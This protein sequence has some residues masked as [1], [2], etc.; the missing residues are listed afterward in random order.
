MA[1]E[2]TLD[3]FQL[4]EILQVVAQQR[5]TGILTIQGTDDIVAVS[6]LEGKIVA[7][8]S[9]TETT[10][11]GVGEVLV[12]DGILEPETLRR[13]SGQS[14]QGGPR[15]GD[16]LVSEDYVSRERYLDALRD[17]TLNLLI[18]L[19][20]WRSGEFKFYG[21]DEVSYEEGFRPI[22]VDELL[23]RSLEEGAETERE[24]LPEESSRLRP[25]ET[26]RSLRVLREEDLGEDPTPV[27]DGDALWLSPEEDRV[28][29]ALRPEHTVGEV[30]E[31]AGVPLDRARYVL[32][33]LSR[34]GLVARVEGAAAEPAPSEVPSEAPSGSG[35]E[36][37]EPATD[38]PQAGVAPSPDLGVPSIEMP[39]VAEEPATPSAR[40]ETSTA[41]P[42][43]AP[44]ERRPPA[45]APPRPSARPGTGASAIAVSI[46]G[47]L[48]LIL[49]ALVLG[50]LGLA[51]GL[52]LEPF[53]WLGAE[54]D[55]LAAMRDEA[56]Q[57][58]IDRA[59]KTYFLLQ[60]HF[61]DRLEDLVEI[62]LLQPDDLFD[63]RG[64]ALSYRAREASYELGVLSS[65]PEADTAVVREG[66]TG[67]FLLDPEF[68]APPEGAQ[69]AEAPLVLLD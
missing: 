60:G 46:T 64:R 61:P 28:L 66:I 41:A 34:A 65:D 31:I 53:P 51:P 69:E 9:L 14:V 59:A 20:E 62:G 32:Y 37:G 42:A 25:L 58:E 5:K 33:R 11:E 3:L 55:E 22:A 10:E 48:G 2:G 44:A 16:L 24:S 23:L 54:R 29:G 43:Q 35:R 7:A 38:P 12:A 1:V 26:E 36:S 39:G 63:A 15:L 18:G 50:V 49:A 52:A 4:P 47:L 56:L 8:D 6:F 21:G 27:E 30:A 13:L 68:L 57:L 45:A 67:N 17:H 19:L 40:P